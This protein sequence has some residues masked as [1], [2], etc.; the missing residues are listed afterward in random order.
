MCLSPL[1]KIIEGIYPSGGSLPDPGLGTNFAQTPVFI[2]RFFIN[3]REK[4][5]CLLSDSGRKTA[6]N[7]LAGIIFRGEE[8]RS[9]LQRTRMLWYKK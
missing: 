9:V 4:L 5:T 3:R 7:D 6:T 8:G 1:T 2:E